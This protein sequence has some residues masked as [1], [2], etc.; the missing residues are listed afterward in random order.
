MELTVK[1]E[2]EN[3]LLGRKEVSGNLAFS[4]TTPSNKEVSEAL[5]KKFGVAADHVAIKHIYGSFGGITGTF[6]AHVYTSKEQLAKVEPK[7]KEPK[8]AAG[9]APAAK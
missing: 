4:N 9:N 8:A 1:N 3:V 5:A 7:K 6:E 2:K